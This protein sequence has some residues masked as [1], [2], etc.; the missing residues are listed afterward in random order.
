MVTRCSRS[1]ECNLYRL[2]TDKITTANIFWAWVLLRTRD[3]WGRLGTVPSDAASR[4]GA[5]CQTAYCTSETQ[6]Q[7]LS[8]SFRRA[9]LNGSLQDM[10]EGPGD[11]LHGAA[12]AGCLMKNGRQRSSYCKRVIEKRRTRTRVRAPSWVDSAIAIPLKVYLVAR[13]PAS[14]KLRFDT[15]V[16][17]GVIIEPTI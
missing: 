1:Q 13:D 2:G 11:V 17:C 9:Q 12:S 3:V 8:V 6:W 15:L 4:R 10:C 14:D 7:T 5:A 16:Q